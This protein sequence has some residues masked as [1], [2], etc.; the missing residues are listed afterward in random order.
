MKMAKR[1][2]N[3]EGTI[4]Q[5]SNG[6][7][8]GQV[9]IDGNRISKSYH[10]QKECR[11]W[12]RQ[13]RD[14]IEDGLNWNSAK[15]T[16]NQY[17]SQWLKDIEGTIKPKTFDQYSSVVSNH[18]NPQLGKI[19]LRELQ[20]YQIQQIYTNLKERGHSQ[21]N[22]QLTHSVLH[23]ALVMA[24]RQG[25]IGRNPAK[26]IVPPKVDQ[27]EMKVLNDNEVR[28]L[29]IGA[30]DNRYEVLYYLAITTGLRQG[31]LLGLMWGDIDWASNT[32]FVQR[33]LRYRRGE[34]SRFAPP[35][36]KAGKR[37]V[38]LGPETIRLLA[39]HRKNQDVER[40]RSD[41]QEFDLVFPSMV[42]TPTSRRNLH[43]FFKRLLKKSDLPD[44]RFHD[45]RH[46]A[47]TLMLQ[48]NIPLIVVSR[49]LGHSKPS[50]TLDIY[51]HYLPG[52]QDEVA[53]LMDEIVTPIPTKLQQIC[54]SN[55][56]MQVEKV[57]L[58]PYVPVK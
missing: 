57:N 43:K 14:Q 44:I 55:E 31:E 15:I 34:G 6:R 37:I 12:I 47:A 3:H 7:W 27:K 45:L 11:A 52:M 1:R 33:Q 53:K 50:I 16:V 18:L 36:T 49:R 26:S 29:L 2:G 48:N 24:E 13:M 30:K 35:K 51:G 32:L 38:Q 17:L 41:W 5:R 42:G 28:Q 9:S 46:S 22:V 56:K 23:R 19:K 40:L 54:N 4:Y 8:V 20:P 21:R 25:L 39:E 10:S 58:P